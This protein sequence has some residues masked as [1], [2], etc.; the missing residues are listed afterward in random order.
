MREKLYI[1]IYLN[2]NYKIYTTIIDTRM[3]VSHFFT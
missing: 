2:Y 1:C 3:E